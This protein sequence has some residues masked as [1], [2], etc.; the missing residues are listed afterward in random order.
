MRAWPPG[1]RACSPLLT[2]TLCQPSVLTLSTC[3]IG[4]DR[5]NISTLYAQVGGSEAIEGVV[6][7]FYARVLADPALAG[8]FGGTN[9]SR[10]KG[11]Q[12]EFI[13][14]A[15]GGPGPYL[16][17]SMKQ[18]HQGRGITMHHFELVGA[19]LRESL[20]AAGVS[21]ELVEQILDKIGSLA[22]DIVTHGSV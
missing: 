5:S 1:A 12:A 14:A 16:G 18:V 4:G 2:T 8:F 6:E 15:L 10:L 3:D 9:M 7:D 22:P 21:D 11:R 13:V 20:G 19:H 17:P